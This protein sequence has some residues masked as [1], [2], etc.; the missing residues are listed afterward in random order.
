MVVRGRFTPVRIRVASGACWAM[1]RTMARQRRASVGE[2]P[3]GREGSR[4]GSH[5]RA[6]LLVR[7]MVYIQAVRSPASWMTWHEIWFCA[8]SC[9]G[10]FPRLNSF[11]FRIRSSQ[12][13]RRR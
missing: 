10:I 11:A 9:N 1:C 8:K 3:N 2:I 13:A 4:L 7:A 5:S 12:R 6:S